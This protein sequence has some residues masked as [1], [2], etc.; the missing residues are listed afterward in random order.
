[1]TANRNHKKAVRAHMAETGL[2]YT[3]AA[4]ALAE[5][6]NTPVVQQSA[7][8]S[9]R[10]SS[11]KKFVDT[12]ELA[13]A[14]GLKP[15]QINRAVRLGM[16]EASVPSEGGSRW[17]WPIG[18]VDTVAPRAAEIAAAVGSVPDMSAWGAADYL[19]D[20][21]GVAVTHKQ[22]TELGHQKLIGVR[23]YRTGTSRNEEWF[24]GQDLEAFTDTAAVMAAER[25][26][27]TLITDQ[28]IE[29]LAV[30]RSDFDALLA[31]GWLRPTDVRRN[32]NG[33]GR[34]K[35]MSIYRQGDVDDLLTSPD[36]DWAAVRAV[37]KGGR[38]LLHKLPKRLAPRG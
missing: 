12:A 17:R 30:R 4:R 31:R 3:A 1:M 19:A 7:A 26:G 33:A 5:A 28:V 6:A 14:T 32:P 36:I 8:P 9:A 35:W 23:N 16:I 29:Q 11:R 15:F 20:K 2:S 34:T 38:S 24:S 25:P 37:P 13:E 10:W 22:V 18:V 21:L 27:Q